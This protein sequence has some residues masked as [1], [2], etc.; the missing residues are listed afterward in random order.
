L[1]VGFFASVMGGSFRH[2]M[3]SAHKN[4]DRLHAA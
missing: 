4:Q 2:V 1:R 3:T